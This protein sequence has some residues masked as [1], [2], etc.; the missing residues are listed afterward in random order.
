MFLALGHF[1]PILDAEAMYIRFLVIGWLV[2][3]GAVRAR[4]PAAAP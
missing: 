4:H 3:A 2:S 1:E